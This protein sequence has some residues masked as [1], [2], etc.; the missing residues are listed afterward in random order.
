MAGEEKKKGGFLSMFVDYDTEETP[1]DATDVTEVAAPAVSDDP[2]AAFTAT[3][4]APVEAAPA[5]PA[6]PPAPKRTALDWTLDEVFAAGKVGTGANS[7]HTVLTLLDNLAQF[8]EPQ[9]LAMIRAMDAADDAWDEPTVKADAEKRVNV[10]RQYGSFIDKDVATRCTA[11][12]SQFE[13]LKTSSDDRIKALEAQIAALQSEREQVM[14]DISES[15]VSAKDRAAAVTKR[16]EDA[17]A[18]AAKEGVR[19]TKLVTFFGQQKG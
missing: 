4:T 16:G 3:P 10:L 15:Q 5:A 7:A 19:Y 18:A 11:I 9:R 8:P 13:G 1:D 12:Q 14:Q 6:A 2:L 17:K